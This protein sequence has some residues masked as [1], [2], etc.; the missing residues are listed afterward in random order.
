VCLSVYPNDLDRPEQTC[1]EVADGIIA[2]SA[3]DES[4]RL[5]DGIVVRNQT[6]RRESGEDRL[7]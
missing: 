7:R 2:E 6:L 5:Q 4:S 1:M 3:L